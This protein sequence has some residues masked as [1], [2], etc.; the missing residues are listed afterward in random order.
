MWLTVAGGL[1][2]LATLALVGVTDGDPGAAVAVPL[3]LV[4]MAG[5]ILCPVRVASTILL[6]CLL[7]FE[8]TRQRPHMDLWRSPLYPV[9]KLFYDGLEK[10][11]SLPGLKI[12]GIEAAVLALLAVL[13][14]AFASGSGVNGLR[15]L[16]TSWEEPFVV[17]D[18]DR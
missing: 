15:E 2:C 16:P 7:L 18:T 5:L 6:F 1:M 11:L 13:A 17:S 3:V 8:D 14:G 9:G 4:I 12:F 10:T